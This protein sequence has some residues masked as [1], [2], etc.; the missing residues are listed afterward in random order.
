MENGADW[1]GDGDVMLSG[2]R[3]LLAAVC[4]GS[5][6]MCLRLFSERVLEKVA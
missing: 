4:G 1:V 2:R 3:L 6:C 5:M